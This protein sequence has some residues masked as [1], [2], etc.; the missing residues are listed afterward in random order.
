[1]TSYFDAQ[2]GRLLDVLDRV[3]ATDNTYV[4]VVSDHG[5]ML[6]ERGSSFKF[7]PFEGSVRIPMIAAGP[8]LKRGHTEA[9]GVSLMDLLPTFND[10]ASD[11]NP[12]AP[13]YSAMLSGLMTA[14]GDVS[15]RP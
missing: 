15:V 11:G 9:R 6:G 8:G 1:M 4:F 13:V 10:L 3:R 14:P 12:I 7:Q 2:V 5:E